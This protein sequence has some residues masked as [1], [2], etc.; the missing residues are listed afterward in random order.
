MAEWSETHT[1][2]DGEWF[3]GN[4]PILGPRSDF[5]PG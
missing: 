3:E 2:L 4:R 1:F 5:D